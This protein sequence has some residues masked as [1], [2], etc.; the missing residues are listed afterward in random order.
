MPLCEEGVGRLERVGADIDTCEGG[1][2]TRRPRRQYWI[3]DPPGK[4][5]R[6][7]ARTTSVSLVT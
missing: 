4:S 1:L 6:I 7:L 2:S 5:A 3:G